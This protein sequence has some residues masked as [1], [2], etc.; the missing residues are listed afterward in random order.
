[1]QD[2]FI[3]GSGTS[4]WSRSFEDCTTGRGEIS[5]LCDLQTSGHYSRVSCAD[6]LKIQSNEQMSSS[7]LKE[8]FEQA[9]KVHIT[10]HIN[11]SSS[12][13]IDIMTIRMQH[14][15]NCRADQAK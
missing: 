6:Q 14:P 4:T 7:N 5:S 9:I 2:T 8:K 3:G 12:N 11:T 15:K 13:W 1:M 10:V